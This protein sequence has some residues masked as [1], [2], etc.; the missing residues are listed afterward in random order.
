MPYIDP[1]APISEKEFAKL[2]ANAG[3]QRTLGGYSTQEQV[4]DY[5][6]NQRLANIATNVIRMNN[7]E[8]IS[9][10]ALVA[11]MNTNWAK[12]VPTAELNYATQQQRRLAES[13]AAAPGTQQG[14]SMEQRNLATTDALNNALNTPGP[15]RSVYDQRLQQMM[16]GSFDSSDPS[17]RWRVEQALTNAGRAGAAR[18]MLGSGNMAAELLTL[19][20]NLASQEYGAQFNRLLQAS[21]NATQHYTAAYGVLDRMLSQQ[22]SQQNLGLQQEQLAQE[23]ARIGQGWNNQNLGMFANDTSRWDAGNR[24]AADAGKLSLARDQFNASEKRLDQWAS[25]E[26]QA[27]QQRLGGGLL[28]GQLKQQQLEREN[29]FYRS[30][31]LNEASMNAMENYY[32]DWKARGSPDEY[33]G[34]SSSARGPVLNNVAS[35]LPSGPGYISNSSGKTTT[36]GNQSPSYQPWGNDY[37][38]EAVYGD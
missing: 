5:Y 25:G 38:Y 1:N 12:Q 19:S 18:G 17:Y 34:T 31:R 32:R 26:N 3:F 2:A 33:A 10:D 24:A 13:A 28:P 4:D 36:F 29:E 7:P 16:L 6:A 21:A 30:G 8:G 35:Q 37:G 9:R 20:S 23:W 27:L 11:Q 15:G 14:I 22:Q